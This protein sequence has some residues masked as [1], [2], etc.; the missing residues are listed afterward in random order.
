[1]STQGFR[2]SPQQRHIWRLQA[3]SRAFRTQCA[4]LIEGEVDAEALRQALTA[5]AARHEVLRTAFR[6]SPGVRFPLQ[7]I[8]EGGPAPQWQTA[9]LTSKP[10]EEQPA[11]LD[12]L[13]RQAARRPFD[14]ER[15]PLVHATLVALG[16]TIGPPRRALLLG[17]PA[18]CADRASLR[19]LL[20]ETVALY[21]GG[22]PS[23]DEETVQ[24]TQV[25]DWQNELLASDESAPGR[26]FW[27]GQDQPVLRSLRLPG[28]GRVGGGFAP[29]AIEIPVEPSTAARIDVLAV[30]T[31]TTAA[32]VLLAAWQ[33]LLARLSGEAREIEVAPG[34]VLD[35]RLQEDFRTAVGPFARCAPLPVRVD[36]ALPFRDLLGRVHQAWTESIDWQDCFAPDEGDR[37]VAGV[38][39]AFELDRIA[40]GE[41]RWSARGAAFSLLRQSS[42]CERFKLGLTATWLEEKLGLEL[43][44]DTRIFT[45]E[46]AAAVAERFRRLLD[47]L[48]AAPD[49]AVGEADILTPGERER[50][51]VE[52]NRTAAP[53]PAER[54]VH[55]LIEEQ[56][57]RTPDAVAV[58]LGEERLT[59]AELNRRANRVARWLLA[60][61]NGPGALIGVC[62]ERAPEMVVAI[63]GALKAG[64]AYLPLDSAYP[65][66]RLAFMIADAG[67]STLI[68]QERVLPSL[69]GA[70]PPERI[71]CLDTQ[72]DRLAGLGGA[73]LP[74]EPPAESL[75]YVIY[76]S[77][78][79]GRPKG[80]M[81]PHRAL[82][83]YLSWAKDAYGLAAGQGTPLHSPIGFDLTVSSLFL[84]L[85][86][87][88][89]VVLVPDDRGVEALAALLRERSGLGLLKMTPAHLALLGQALAGTD[90]ASRVGTV[91]LGGEGL[92][93]EAVAP[94]RE[95]AGS[96]T[97]VNEY[98]P[99]EATVGC[100]VYR[101]PASGEL[102][103]PV[104]IGRPIANTRLYVLDAASRPA[105]EGVAGELFIAGASLALGYLG[106]PDLTAERF[107]PDPFAAEAGEAGEPGARVYRT[108]D[109]ARWLPQGDLEYV[110]R[111]DHQVKVRGVRIELGEIESVLAGHPGVREAAVAAREDTPGD[112]RLVA[113]VVPGQ[114]PAP[115]VDELRRFLA[116]RLPDTMVPS[117]FVTLP[118]LP[119]T[120]HGKLDRAALPAP[121]SRRPDLEREYVEPRTPLEET[122]A[123][124]WREVLGLDKVGV[125]DSFFALG[126]DSIRSVRVVALAQEKGIELSVEQL[127][128]R[129]TIAALAEDAGAAAPAA[130]DDDLARLVAELEDLS[131][132]EVEARLREQM[133]VQGEGV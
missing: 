128:R 91:V 90:L 65:P 55:R 99:T 42:C 74:E 98:G 117:A 95:R 20:A 66:E 47:S 87:G 7:V 25:S 28:E 100:C 122:L 61:G 21:G 38:T 8:P 94:W 71:L 132:D 73:D 133:G 14:V 32:S 18:L 19:Q 116:E 2:L 50:L 108:G 107:L 80:V 62:M 102:A 45:A 40:A 9:D 41:G 70:V 35:G 54:C 63:F 110:G 75:A 49:T 1:M 57:A 46:A 26:D 27:R 51:I 78:S 124:I 125:L 120:V 105:P 113:Y 60:S 96:T 93:G 56:A 11:A 5:A 43:W 89:S 15:G 79:T 68:A 112:R 106:R 29:E 30:T 130:G 17:A 104:P 69:V 53:F 76:T 12:E 84:P 83:N 59:Y 58:E 39:A 3:D 119:L 44:H 129:Q 77:G 52:R 23:E 33:A 36:P 67:V 6:R 118:S 121:G 31:G 13:F 126:G 64:A 131:E 111:N 10:A 37:A 109:L 114:E 85:L 127:F 48:L 82:L 81:V 86:S 92:F 115:N 123:E 88:G 103:G 16:P 97:I 34:V 72:Q 22:A 24:Y 101:L 4:V